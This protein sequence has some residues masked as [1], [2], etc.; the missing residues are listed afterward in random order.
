[1]CIPILPHSCYIPYPSH[2]PW[3]DHSNYTRRRV[4]VMQL[5]PLHIPENNTFRRICLKSQVAHFSCTAC[6]ESEFRTKHRV[7]A[8]IFFSKLFCWTLPIIL[9]IYKSYDISKAGSASVV[10]CKMNYP[11]QLGPLDSVTL[12]HWP[13]DCLCLTGPTE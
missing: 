5:Q 2:P 6:F 10:R 12:N 1:M 8:S 3:L 4:Q 11:T 13:W 9:V 7:P